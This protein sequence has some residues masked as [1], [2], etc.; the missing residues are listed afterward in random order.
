MDDF[1]WEAVGG[2]CIL[3]AN[4]QSMLDILM[5]MQ[6][7]PDARCWAKNWPF[8]IPLLGLLMRLCGHLLVDDFNILPN[9]QQAIL[10]GSSLYVFP[11]GTRS[12]TG[13]VGRFRDGAFLLAMKTGRPIVP[14]ALHGSFDCFPPGQ[15]WIWTRQLRIQPLG[16]LWPNAHDPK[17]HI[18]L[19]R[20]ARRMII[21]ALYSVDDTAIA[22]PESI[23]SAA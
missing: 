3:I 15:A 19:R 13:K 7:P 17:D 5:M 16:I 9:A 22:L 4:H 11:E 1:N 23:K 18:R 8:R 14:V 6:L 12:R 10:D 2:P 20:E 21:S